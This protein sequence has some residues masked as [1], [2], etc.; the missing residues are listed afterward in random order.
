MHLPYRK[1][2]ERQVTQIECLA[3]GE[4]RVVAALAKN[5][6]GTCPRCGYGGWTYAEELDGTTRRLHAPD[7]PEGGGAETTEK[8]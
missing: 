1:R 7:P 4:M 5:G 2:P 3:C 8:R 6:A